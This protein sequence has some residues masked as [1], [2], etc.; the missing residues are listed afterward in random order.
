MRSWLSRWRR[1]RATAPAAPPW[2]DG[3][4]AQDEAARAEDREAARQIA[5]AM[6]GHAL[7]PAGLERRATAATHA[8]RRRRPDELAEAI[9][10][11]PYPW[12]LRLAE[13]LAARPGLDRAGLGETARR[14]VLET[15][16]RD[17]ALAALAL[18]SLAPSPADVDLLERAARSA[19]GAP[20]AARV[21]GALPGDAGRSALLA[22][23]RRA[24]GVG[25]ALAIE[26]RL[27]SRPPGDDAALL[28]E[29]TAGIDDPLDRA[30]AAV[31]L[32]EAIDPDALL[33]N[34]PDLAEA[35][36]RAVESTARGGWHGGPGPGL[37]RLPGSQRAALCLLRGEVEA[38]LRTRV[39]RAVVEAHPAAA[40]EVLRL[41]D[42]VL[43]AAD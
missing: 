35:L 18:L 1:R 38:A 5:R 37:G 29:L 21:A 40:G 16:G 25:R 24:E 33:A 3:L 32:L 17:A 15:P 4:D 10:G 30:W 26:E 22:V 20:A 2:I 12:A 6:H 41:A 13:R 19:V 9:E 43:A 39:A 28:L 36:A 8:A 11:L 31:P 42:Q 23:I 7:P 14:V 34:R 27:R